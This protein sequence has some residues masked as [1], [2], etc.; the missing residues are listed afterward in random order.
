METNQPLPPPT[1]SLFPFLPP[2][3]PFTFFFFL[4]SSP[5]KAHLIFLSPEIEKQIAIFHLEEEYKHALQGAEVILVSMWL[6][7][8]GPSEK[9]SSVT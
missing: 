6:G 1:P 4:L 2:F 9:G 8:E 3:L 7:R 5:C